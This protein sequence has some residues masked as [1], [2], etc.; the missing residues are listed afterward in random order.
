[1]IISH[2]IA[3]MNVNFKDGKKLADYGLKASE[4]GDV[5]IQIGG[6]DGV[7]SGL[8]GNMFEIDDENFDSVFYDNTKYG[9]TT[10]VPA[11]F[12]GGAVLNTSDIKSAF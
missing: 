1:M 12:T 9:S 3:A 4:Y 11:I 7:I 2:N 5:S 8:K 10:E 6:E